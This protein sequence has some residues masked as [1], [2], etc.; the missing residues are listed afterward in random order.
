MR[1]LLYFLALVG[2]RHVTAEC[3]FMI[4]NAPVTPRDE[5]PSS[6][7]YLAE[8]EVDDD[9]QYMTSDVGG[10][11]DDQFSLRAGLRGPTLLEDFR[12]RQK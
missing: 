8:Y 3:P 11:I 12:L 1:S 5:K 2:S 6:P 9:N 4:G 7:E 10:P